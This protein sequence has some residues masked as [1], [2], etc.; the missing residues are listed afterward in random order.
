MG[1]PEIIYLLSGFPTHTVLDSF[2]LPLT[3]KCWH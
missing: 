2:H 1:L 3:P